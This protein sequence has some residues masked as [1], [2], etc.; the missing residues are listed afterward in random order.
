H[1]NQYKPY[2]SKSFFKNVSSLVGLKTSSE[3]DIIWSSICMEY[4]SHYARP[5][6][7]HSASGNY[8]SPND[9]KTFFFRSENIS[10]RTSA[11][12]V[13]LVMHFKQS[14]IFYFEKNISHFSLYWENEHGVY[15]H[16]YIPKVSVGYLQI[17]DIP[18]FPKKIFWAGL[19]F[20]ADNVKLAEGFALRT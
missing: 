7:M 14:L 5:F 20:T 8:Y 6:Y 12:D 2:V 16:L 15:Q 17:P 3:D 10:F 9:T 19:F 18:T 4:K 11:E 1:L 13:F